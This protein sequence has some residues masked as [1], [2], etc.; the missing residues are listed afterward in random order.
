MGNIVSF[1]SFRIILDRTRDA[2]GQTAVKY[3]KN[4]EKNENIRRLPGEFVCERLQ[5][6]TDTLLHGDDWK[7]KKSR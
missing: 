2:H 6:Q 7:K 3:C 1:T 4:I 5:V